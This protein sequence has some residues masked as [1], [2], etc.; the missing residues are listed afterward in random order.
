[1]GRRD[2]SWLVGSVE[3]GVHSVC[4]N[5][6]NPDVPSNMRVFVAFELIQAVPQSSWLNDAEAKNIR[7][8]LVTLDTS[9]FE[10]STLN[11]VAL[12]NISLMSVTLDTSHFE[13]S[14]L[15]AAEF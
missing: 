7:S 12:E 8:I 13:M 15:N 5:D 3:A 4:D 1:M 14:P 11:N 9:H 10:M 2:T 6:A